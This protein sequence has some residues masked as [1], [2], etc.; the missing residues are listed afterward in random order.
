M[1]PLKRPLMIHSPQKPLIIN[2]SDTYC[3]SLASSSVCFFYFFSS[4]S[5]E[6][7]LQLKETKATVSMP[8]HLH[9][10]SLVFHPPTVASVGKPTLQEVNLNHPPTRL[11]RARP[12][13]L[14]LNP[15][16][17]NRC[18][19]DIKINTTVNYHRWVSRWLGVLGRRGT[20]RVS[21]MKIN[22][23]LKRDYKFNWVNFFTL[24]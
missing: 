7:V 19:F 13:L 22:S 18:N 21:E 24:V 15:S 23:L 20:H 11:G 10:S 16:A 6:N 8:H 12:Q 1:Q 17:R 5:F 14:P 3:S 9:L 4:E 2:T